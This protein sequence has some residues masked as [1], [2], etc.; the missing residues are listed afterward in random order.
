MRT[1]KLGLDIGNSSVKGNVLSEDNRL[2]DTV[3]LPSS[4]CELTDE[5]YLTFTSPSVKYVQIVESPLDHSSN[6]VAIG[7]DALELPNY[8]EFNVDTSSYKTNHR[9]TNSLLMG[10]IARFV[11]TKES[12]I[13][14]TLG[15]SIP[16]VEAKTLELAKKYQ[17]LLLGKHIIKIY[18]ET[19][20]REVVIHV[21]FAQI[22]N[23]GQAGFL[24]LLDNNN[25]DF[26]TTMDHLYKHLKETRESITELEDF[27]VIDIGEG[28]TDFAVFRNKKFNPAF[29]Y[30]LTKG[31][32]NILEKAI[33][34]AQRDGLTIESRK[35]LQSLLQ[36]KNTRRAKQKEMWSGYLQNE[37]KQY[38]DEVIETILKAY[39]RQS[40][41]DAIIFL[42]G[43]F[44]AI[45]GYAV[46][47]NGIHKE[48]DYLFKALDTTLE[49]NK[50]TASLIFGVP[51][52]YAQGINAR[53]LQ[54]IIGCH[55]VKKK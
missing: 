42:G 6:I 27:L 13:Q 43:G 1:I 26:K 8:Q 23:E 12:E 29:S 54:Q 48:N 35:Q 51:N 11:Q 2:I 40:F 15:L 30:S 21:A 39:N 32:G 16:I 33:E 4:I 53:G 49:K 41:F 46:D 22:L 14:V 7:Q 55:S 24:G 17:E 9:I 25:K 38:L 19:G 36:S 44:S 31:Y 52:A 10:V 20:S 45:T 18:E 37:V 3:F 34:N 50:K 5:K 28:T 47:S